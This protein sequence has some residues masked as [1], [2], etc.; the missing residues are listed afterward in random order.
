MSEDNK[1]KTNVS[2]FI[3]DCNAG[4]LHEKLAYLLSEA[5]LAQVNNGS[6][7]K[8]ANVSLEFSFQQMGDN[9]Q[10][11]VSHKISMTK[12][13]KRGKKQEEDITESVFFV[14]KGGNLTALPPE[15]EEGGQFSLESQTDKSTGEIKE[16]SAGNKV[17]SIR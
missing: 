9:P 7:N 2:D 11:I 13:T 10:V 16:F 3:Q 17:R 8:K 12:P 15:E 6:G 5:A 1:F 4:I 14:G